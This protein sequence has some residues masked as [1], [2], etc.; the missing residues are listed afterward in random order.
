MVKC[1]NS[2]PFQ[3]HECPKCGRRYADRKSLRIHLFTHDAVKPFIC[4][5]CSQ[6]RLTGIFHSHVE[7]CLLCLSVEFVGIAMAKVVTE[8]FFAIPL[9]QVSNLTVTI[10]MAIAHSCCD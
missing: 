7:D 1:L 5:I 6:G 4:H 3:P 10:L 2:H 9:F 8:T